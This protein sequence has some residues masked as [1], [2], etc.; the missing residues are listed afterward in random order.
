MPCFVAAQ[1]L[2]FRKAIG[3][4]IYLFAALRCTLDADRMR[5]IDRA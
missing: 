5:D 1:L 3:T 4:E 2:A